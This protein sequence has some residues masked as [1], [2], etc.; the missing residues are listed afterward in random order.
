VI[1]GEEQ[2]FIVLKEMRDSF[3]ERLAKVELGETNQVLNNNILFSKSTKSTL[4]N[5][6]NIY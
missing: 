6:S 4:P 5:Y 3:L 1:E 2:K